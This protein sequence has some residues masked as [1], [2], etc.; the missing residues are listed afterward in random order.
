[1]T[2]KTAYRSFYY[3][4]AP[5]PEDVLLVPVQTALLVIDVQN[6]YLE[7]KLDPADD[8]R[9]QPFLA[10]MRETVIPNT[11]RLI[12]AWRARGVEIIFAR[13]ACLK[14]DGRDPLAQSEEAGLQLP[15]AAEGPR[16]LAD[17]SGTRPRG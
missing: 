6:T 1:M 8:A 9:W 14:A 3:Q 16:G 11:A 4:N 7:P 13:I 5:K 12:A 17:R 2:W 10:R 15:F